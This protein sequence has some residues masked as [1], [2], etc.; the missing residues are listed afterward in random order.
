MWEELPYHRV[1]V[2]GTFDYNHEVILRN[3]RYEDRPGVFVLTPLKI[4]GTD[5][6]VLVSRGF[7]PIQYSEPQDRAGFKRPSHSSFTGLIKASVPRRFLAP[8]DPPTGEGNPRVDAFLRVDLVKIGAQMPYPIL[9]VWI[10]VMHEGDNIDPKS[11]II[12]TKDE[13][14]DI[15]NPAQVLDKGV[16]GRTD[17][18]PESFPVPVFDT[19]VPAGRHLGY[20]F[21]WALMAVATI[22]IAIVLQLRPQRNTRS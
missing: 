19:I 14:D 16:L 15:M 7:A 4:D 10:E 8:A 1:T 9:P 5:A 2:S 20:V 6:T 13:R 22:L 21:E 12:R 3:R 17:L 11:E 18:P